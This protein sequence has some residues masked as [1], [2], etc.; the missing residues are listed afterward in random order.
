MAHPSLVDLTGQRFGKLTVMIQEVGFYMEHLI[1][2]KIVG[3]NSLLFR[4]FVIV[5]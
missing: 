5:E 2:L 3:Q 1:T 4:I